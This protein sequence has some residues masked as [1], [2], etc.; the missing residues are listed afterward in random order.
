MLFNILFATIIKTRKLA[1]F[2]HQQIDLDDINDLSTKKL[3]K[4]KVIDHN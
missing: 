1:E 2:Q 3:S 4:K